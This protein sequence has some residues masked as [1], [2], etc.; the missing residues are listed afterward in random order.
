M[1]SP[2]INYITLADNT[3]TFHME[4]LFSL[5]FVFYGLISCVGI[6]AI[7]FLA[8]S[9]YVITSTSYVASTS[10]DTLTSLITPTSHDVSLDDNCI[11]CRN[12]DVCELI[13]K[14]LGTFQ[15][16]NQQFFTEEQMFAMLQY[17]NILRKSEHCEIK[18]EK[19]NVLF[20]FFETL[21]CSNVTYTMFLILFWDLYK[22]EFDAYVRGSIN[23]D[24]LSSQQQLNYWIEKIRTIE[25]NPL[26][27]MYGCSTCLID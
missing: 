15:D 25:K 10:C 14:T 19:L 18:H 5:E 8:I 12:G 9:K 21:I 22:N 27:I 11:R 3:M 24:S 13:E 26:E 1:L 17:L 4:L 23:F 7:L 20:D 6:I 2:L 16:R